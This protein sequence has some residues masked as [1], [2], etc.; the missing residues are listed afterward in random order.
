MEFWSYG[1]RLLLRVVVKGLGL[2]LGFGIRV[3]ELGC[4]VIDLGVEVNL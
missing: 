1:Y 4:V 2:F 3:S